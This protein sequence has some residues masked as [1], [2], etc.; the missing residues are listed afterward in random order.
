[1]DPLEQQARLCS[2]RDPLWTDDR[3]GL[4]AIPGDQRLWQRAKAPTKLGGVTTAALRA[5]TTASLL[6]PT[7]TLQ[8]E[9]RY[10]PENTIGVIYTKDA[11]GNPYEVLLTH[12]KLGQASGG[13]TD[14]GSPSVVHNPDEDG[15]F[16]PQVQAKER[17]Q[18]F[19][20]RKR[21]A[22]DVVDG[23]GNGFDQMKSTALADNLRSA[24]EAIIQ[25]RMDAGE[26][27]GS[28]SVPKPQNN[29]G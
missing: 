5:S 6:A 25:K 4:D 2:S 8:G 12:T 7:S 16:T 18:E 19:I 29:N 20:S 13:V 17:A 27:F 23:F 28:I 22:G 14:D 26:S 9:G 21:T 15:S 10:S 24:Q 3:H 11:D 1:M